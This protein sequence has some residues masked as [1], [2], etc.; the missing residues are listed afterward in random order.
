[1]ITL[2]IQGIVQKRIV[3]MRGGIRLK[4]YVQVRKGGLRG[5]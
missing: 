1:M 4:W 2:L 3:N 5:T